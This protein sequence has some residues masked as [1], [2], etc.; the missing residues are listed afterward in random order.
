[1]K[2]PT[3]M[4]NNG[5]IEVRRPIAAMILLLALGIGGV[6]G[7]W[8]TGRRSS[9]GVNILLSTASAAVSD[10]VS[11]TSGFTP[12]VDRVLPSV[13]NISSAKIVRFADSGPTSPFFF[14]PFFHE[15][16]GGEGQGRD[17]PREQREL[18]LGSGVIVSPDGYLLTNNH[19]VEGGSE[20]R[21]SLTD[22]REMKAKI[23]GT[24]PRTDIAVLKVD[25]MNLPV[26]P[27]GDSAGAKPGQFVLAVGNSFGLGQ[28][29]T[30]GIVSATGR[31]NLHIVD[32]E[33]F[34][35]TDA[36]IN[37]GN[38]GGALVDVRGALIGINTAILSRSGGNQGIGF[39]V[40][41]NMARQVMERIVKEGKVVRGWLGVVIQPVT[42]TIARAFEKLVFNPQPSPVAAEAAAAKA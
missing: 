11:F 38:S 39:A 9:Q 17:H 28:T 24:D 6:A 36:A 14:D 29:V 23:V 33:D 25:Q 27:I 18:S 7:L 37:P 42:P 40:P 35:Q 16:F 15:F 30:L 12:V 31:G 20:I 26:L 41:I 1:M 10:Q 21:I 13:V 2:G 34:I 19:V 8:I 22:K 32:Y 5:W 4:K 3:P